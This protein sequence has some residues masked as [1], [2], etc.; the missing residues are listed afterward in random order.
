MKIISKDI[1][2]EH[3]QW[4]V[5]CDGWHLVK[6]KKLSIIQERVPPG[7]KEI[8]HFHKNAEQ[9][10]FVLFGEAVLEI[11]GN[12]HILKAHQGFHVPS[13]VPHQLKNESTAPLEF[14]VTSTPP[15]HGDRFEIK[16]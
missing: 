3:Y 6:S 1:D 4:G 10:F 14:I 12:K 9:F 8:K 15:S 16:T 7:G 5:V 11:S 13:G 2:A